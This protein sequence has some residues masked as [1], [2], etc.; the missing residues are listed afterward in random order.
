MKHED[1]IREDVGA[2]ELCA[3]L[4]QYLETHYLDKGQQ[5]VAISGVATVLGRMLGESDRTEK[6]I[7]DISAGIIEIAEFSRRQKRA[8][9]N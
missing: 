3:K 8:K 1:K 5:K 7:A 2:F 9:N 4:W 6:E